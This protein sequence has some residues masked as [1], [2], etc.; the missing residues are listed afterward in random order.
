[1][2]WRFKTQNQDDIETDFVISK[3][4]NEIV[5][6]VQEWNIFFKEL[7]K[8]FKGT[9]NTVVAIL[10]PIRTSKLAWND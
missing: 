4:F 6:K 10:N 9:T 7:N 5:K 8:F 2:P 3:S 1:M